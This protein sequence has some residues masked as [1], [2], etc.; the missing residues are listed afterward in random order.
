[1]GWGS[2]LKVGGLE[3]A[4]GTRG[5]LHV[6]RAEQAKVG[7]WER[8]RPLRSGSHCVCFPTGKSTG[9]NT[10]QW[11]ATRGTLAEGVS[12]QGQMQMLCS[13]CIGGTGFLRFPRALPKN[14]AS[15]ACLLLLGVLGTGRGEEAGPL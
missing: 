3:S 8:G 4:E 11:C 6:T 7:R 2:E 5:T 12:R 9:G 1:M 14:V 15:A 10:G 13:T